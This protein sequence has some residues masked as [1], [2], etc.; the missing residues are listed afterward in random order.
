MT[1]YE[2]IQELVRYEADAEIEVSVFTD[3]LRTDATA[4]EEAERGELI[5]AKA[6]IDEHTDDI[7]VSAYKKHTGKHVVCIDVKLK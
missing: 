7:I 1:V 4:L 3:G 6:Y 2:M 5:D